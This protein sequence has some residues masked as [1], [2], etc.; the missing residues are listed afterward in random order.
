MSVIWGVAISVGIKITRTLKIAVAGTR[1]DEAIL[2]QLLRDEVQLINSGLTL[3]S[4]FRYSKLSKRDVIALLG[5]ATSEFFILRGTTYRKQVLAE[6][7]AAKVYQQ[8]KSQSRLWRR[9]V[10]LAA[11]FADQ[12]DYGFL[13][14][15]V[16]D[17]SGT[18]SG[19]RSVVGDKS[20]PFGVTPESAAE[21]ARVEPL[22]PRGIKNPVACFRSRACRF[23]RTRRGNYAVRLVH[24]IRL[25]RH[26]FLRVVG[27]G[28]D[29]FIEEILRRDGPERGTFTAELRREKQRLVL[30]VYFSRD[31]TSP[32][33]AGRTYVGMDLGIVNVAVGAAVDPIRGLIKPKFWHGRAIRHRLRVL[34]AR[35]ALRTAG[36]K[37]PVVVADYKRYWTYRIAHEIVEFAA[38]YPSPV[39]VLEDLRTM[40]GKH[41]KWSRRSNRDLH[42]WDYGRMRDFIA[43]L[44]AWQSIRVI[45][46][47]ARGTSSTCP[48][49]GHGVLRRRAS[50]L[51]KCLN[52]ECAYQNNDDLVGAINVALRGAQLERTRSPVPGHVQAL[53]AREAGARIALHSDFHST[54]VHPTVE[55]LSSAGSEGV[56]SSPSDDPKQ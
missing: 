39:I 50:H 16:E 56:R 49:C 36:L 44:A 42:S 55:S 47:Q 15:V 24:P 3:V 23:V 1:R 7:I 11:R 28:H 45:E 6:G 34:D 32:D 38:G 19:L 21:F 43:H 5:R 29:T 22:F 2:D 14:G 48:K 12:I 41:R 4:R 18:W 25:R 46:V 37:S 30:H 40:K 9:Q 53:E 52:P 35:N 33:Y 20:I 13:Q 31:V 26:M 8:Y 54:T 27:R 17:E 51:S 10:F